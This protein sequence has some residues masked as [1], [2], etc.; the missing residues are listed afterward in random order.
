[1]SVADVLIEGS[2]TGSG[3]GEEASMPVYYS[4]LHDTLPLQVPLC[5]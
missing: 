5:L 4:Y 3:V 2:W 1:M